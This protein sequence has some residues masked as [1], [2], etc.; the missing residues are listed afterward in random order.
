VLCCD[1][2]HD[3]RHPSLLI[4]T[5]GGLMKEGGTLVLATQYLAGLS[6]IPMLYLPI[7][8]ESPQRAE[9]CSFFTLAGLRNLLTAY[10]FHDVRVHAE[11]PM[12]VSR[13]RAFAQ[14]PFEPGR[15]YHDSE[16]AV[17][18]VVL[19]CRWDPLIA[20]RDPRYAAD[21]AVGRS[22]VGV[23][24]S[25]LPRGGPP[26][27]AAAD[28]LL[29]MLDAQVH[30][31]RDAAARLERELEAAA[32]ALRDRERDLDRT[33]VELV[34]R[35]RELDLARAELVGR[36]R[37]LDAAREDLRQRTD[38]LV[39]TR[40]ELDRRRRLERVDEKVR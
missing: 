34:D 4:R 16:S 22:L 38:E 26:E 30:R 33:R 3:T 31:H 23:W 8:T 11:L 37:E 28:R 14:M 13:E 7:G 21:R 20:D 9:G 32:A 18:T 10:G 2:L 40:H 17:A 19:T 1:H 35:T 36:T 6:A 29:V 39:R 15:V 5:L 27:R 24:D 25:E 12:A